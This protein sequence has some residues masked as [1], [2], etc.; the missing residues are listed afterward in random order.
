VV[1]LYVILDVFSRYIVGWTVQ[2]HE[3]AQLA[4][5]LIEQATG[6]ADHPEILTLAR[7]SRR[8]VCAPSYSRNCSKTSASRSRIRAVHLQRQPVL[9]AGFKTLKYRPTFP[10][11]FND[12]EHAR[13]HCRAFVD[14][15]HT[16]T[17]TPGSD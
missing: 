12:I 15:Y 8:A 1:Y 10:T 4:T 16:S 13:E 9:E 14:W 2:Q 3:N 7:R 17:A 5:A 11:R 6:A